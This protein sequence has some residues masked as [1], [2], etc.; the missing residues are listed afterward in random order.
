VFARAKKHRRKTVVI[1]LICRFVHTVRETEFFNRN[2]LDQANT[3]DN[4][5]FICETFTR[6]NDAQELPEFMRS[7]KLSRPDCSTYLNVAYYG[8]TREGVSCRVSIKVAAP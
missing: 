7:L 2:K 3:R 8:K 1:G 4:P 6:V 5:D